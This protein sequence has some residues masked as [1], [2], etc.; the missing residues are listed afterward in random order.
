MSNLAGVLGRQGKY[1]EVEAMYRQTL[2]RRE[3]VLGAEHLDTLA[4]IYCLAHFLARQHRY[5][6]AD[7]LYQRVCMGRKHVL[8]TDH[9]CIRACQQHYSEMLSSREQDR[10][11]VPFPTLQALKTYPTIQREEARDRSL[12]SHSSRLNTG[13]LEVG[14][15]TP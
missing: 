14:T 11:A 15:T 4:S 12:R 3:K 5:N 2:A 13:S 6:E 7:P 10:G 9:P 1:S 8:G